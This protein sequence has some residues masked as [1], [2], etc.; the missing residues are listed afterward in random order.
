MGATMTDEELAAIEAR[1][2]GLPGE[3]WGVAGTLSPMLVTDLR[4][5]I[6]CGDDADDVCPDYGLRLA[7]FPVGHV[8][9]DPRVW[10][11]IAHARTDVPALV[12]EVRRL[13]AALAGGDTRSAVAVADST[14]QPDGTHAAT[15]RWPR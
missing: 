13:R 1:A 15:V 5:V 9:D 7:T 12:A 11:F 6:R 8:I 2:D 3:T 10:D 4:G 14:P